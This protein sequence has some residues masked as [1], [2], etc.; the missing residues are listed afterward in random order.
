MVVC[1]KFSLFILYFY[2]R[3]EIQSSFA[4]AA[5]ND[6]SVEMPIFRAEH[7]TIGSLKKKIRVE[8]SRSSRSQFFDYLTIRLIRVVIRKTKNGEEEEEEEE[9]FK[10]I[11]FVKIKQL[12]YKIYIHTDKSL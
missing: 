1:V 11:S 9:I 6:D 2:L 8:E 12:I 5:L 7:S 10:L 4:A 3:M